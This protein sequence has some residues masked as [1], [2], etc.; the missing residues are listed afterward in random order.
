VRNV[1]VVSHRFW[2]DDLCEAMLFDAGAV[3]RLGKSPTGLQTSISNGRGEAGIIKPS[4]FTVEWKKR[5][6]TYWTRPA[7]QILAL[8]LRRLQAADIA[9]LAVDAVDAVKPLTERF[10]PGSR[11]R[12]VQDCSS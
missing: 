3:D 8:R 10:G 9:I 2:E 6:S 12:A 1:A 4:L 5:R 11:P 7:T